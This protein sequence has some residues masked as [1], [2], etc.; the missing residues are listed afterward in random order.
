MTMNAETMLRDA[1][2]TGAGALPVPED[3]W[4]GFAQR[5]KS[6]RRKRRI[7]VG[8]A[9]AAVVAAVGV[10]TGIVPLP[11]WAP[12]FA[13]AGRETALVNSPARGSLAGDGAFLAG[14]RREVKDVQDPDELWKVADRNKI[15]LVY[16]TDLPDR[17]LALVLVPLRFGFLTDQALIWYEGDRG[18]SPSRMTEGARVDG[19]ETVVTYLDGTGDRPGIA[20]VVAPAGSTISI[21]TGFTYTAQGRVEHNE[22]VVPA[23]G[24]GIAEI[25]VPPARGGPAVVATV[26]RGERVLYR[27]GLDGGWS[28]TDT[29]VSG[30]QLD[31]ILRGGAFDRTSVQRWA[32]QA[33]M[34]ARLTAGGTAIG[35]PWTGTVNGQPAALLTLRQPG[36]GVLVYAFHGGSDAFRQDLRLLL[37]AA[38]ADRRPIAWRMRAEGKDDRTDQVNVVA[39]AGAARATLTVAGAAAVPVALDATGF[40]T[41][42]LDPGATASVTSYAKDG[43]VLGVTPVPPFETDSGGIPG[44]DPRTRIVP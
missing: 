24:S 11:G 19:G 25:T 43:S 37:P 2:A 9:A 10:Q 38:G 34:N 26:T 30:P 28:G 40:G 20:V 16:A 14:L 42:T 7:R 17:R 12:G 39:P 35:L 13:V 1:L 3:P 22:A 8:A 29:E 41:A 23:P 36:H 44:D 21:T 6:H 15:K 27:G 33:L 5:E 31:R 4:S 18:A 32:D